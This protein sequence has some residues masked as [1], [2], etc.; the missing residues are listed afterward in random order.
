MIHVSARHTVLSAM[1]QNWAWGREGRCRNNSPNQSEAGCQQQARSQK[2][3][4]CVKQVSLA[5]QPLSP[6]CGLLIPWATA[7]T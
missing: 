6:Q 7:K 2:D 5:S 4:R 3:V 1:T